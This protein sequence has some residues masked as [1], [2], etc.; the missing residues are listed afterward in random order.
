MTNLNNLGVHIL[1]YPTGKYGYVGTLPARLGYTDKPTKSD[2]MAGRFTTA[3]NGQTVTVKFPVF[4]TVEDTV[5]HAQERQ[6]GLCKSETCACAPIIA[7]L[8]A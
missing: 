3:P 7:G 6:V 8:S 4:D 5:L 2:I 1:R